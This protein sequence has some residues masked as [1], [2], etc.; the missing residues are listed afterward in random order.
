[1]NKME[2]L[3]KTPKPLKRTKRSPGAKEN[4]E[5]FKNCNR[6]AQQ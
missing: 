1:M 6:H 2:S 5:R 3:I 4:N